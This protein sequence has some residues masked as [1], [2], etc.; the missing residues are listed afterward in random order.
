M[1][2]P[3]QAQLWAGCTC[4][5]SL[6]TKSVRQLLMAAAL[7]CQEI[8]GLW[9]KSWLFE[10]L[11][12]RTSFGT[13]EWRYGGCS[14]FTSAAALKGWSGYWALPESVQMGS[15]VIIRQSDCLWIWGIFYQQRNEKVWIS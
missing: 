7:V 8:L 6:N 14:V 1:I 2:L 4:T 10:K 13:P 15:W 5:T 12:D 3:A 11:R 9:I